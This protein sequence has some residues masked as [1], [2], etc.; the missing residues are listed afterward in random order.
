MVL[1]IDKC[2][3]VERIIDELRKVNEYLKWRWSGFMNS[4]C[5]GVGSFI[6]AY[7]QVRFLGKSS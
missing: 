3:C 6:L 7:T 2:G 4:R 5:P 1:F